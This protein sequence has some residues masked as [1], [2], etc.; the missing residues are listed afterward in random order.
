MQIQEFVE[1][2]TVVLQKPIT[3]HLLQIKSVGNWRVYVVVYIYQGKVIDVI[4]Q[5]ISKDDYDETSLRVNLEAEYGHFLK[6][7]NKELEYF[8]DRCFESFVVASSFEKENLLN[9]LLSTI[10]DKYLLK[11][12]PYRIECLDISHLS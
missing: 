9:D 7:P 10:Q 5:K 8:L 11:H 6:I 2:Q 3:G 12:F 1:K 4:R